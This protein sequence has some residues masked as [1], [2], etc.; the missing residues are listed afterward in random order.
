MEPSGWIAVSTLSN[1]MI[2]RLSQEHQKGKHWQWDWSSWWG[3]ALQEVLW[4][5]LQ[6]GLWLELHC[7]DCLHGDQLDTACAWTSH[8]GVID[9]A[10]AFMYLYFSNWHYLTWEYCAV[11]TR[12]WSACIGQCS[13]FSLHSCSTAVY[14]LAQMQGGGNSHIG[15]SRV[16]FIAHQ[17]G[18][19]MLRRS[20]Q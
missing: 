5:C 19:M 12:S 2:S 15:C 11:V 16:E 9:G 7:C 20:L 3:N 10:L 17:H 14:G 8:Y 6:D 1:M 18:W 13:G 4:N